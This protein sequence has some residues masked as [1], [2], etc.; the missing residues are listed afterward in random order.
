MPVD[1]RPESVDRPHVGVRPSEVISPLRVCA[2]S[3]SHFSAILQKRPPHVHGLC[4]ALTH[5]VSLGLLLCCLPSDDRGGRFSKYEGEG[6]PLQ[7]LYCCASPLHPTHPPPMK[8][9][10]VQ[11]PGLILKRH[12]SPPVL[13]PDPRVTPQRLTADATNYR[14]ACVISLIHLCMSRCRC[15]VFVVFVL[16]AFWLPLLYAFVG[17]LIPTGT[18]QLQE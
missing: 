11:P 5:A 17:L 15:H 10:A 3:Y 18:Y 2:T 4:F 8:A 16:V 14:A 6:R 9:C 1:Q 12:R 7:I 13:Q